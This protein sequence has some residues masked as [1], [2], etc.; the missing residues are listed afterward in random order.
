MEQ[1]DT[2]EREVGLPDAKR[3]EALARLAGGVAHDLNNILGA[4]D[5]YASLLLRTLPAEG[6]AALDT[7][8]I[9]R[10][11]AA[12]TALTGRLLAFSRPQIIQKEPVDVKALLAGLA[13]KPGLD[14]SI[15]TE[16]GLPPLQAS[17]G[18]LGGALQ[19][20]LD[21]A[22]A[23]VDRGGAVRIKAG[24]A[25]GETGAARLRITVE[26]TGC[27]M[28]PEVLEHAF[29]PYFTTRDKGQGRGLG[30]FTVRGAVLQHSGTAEIRSAPG[31]GTEVTISLPLA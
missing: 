28:P 22:A 21:N 7:R 1:K 4:I 3:L 14:L 26:D 8:E 19:C 11:A 5:G 9:R 16:P 13:C 10:A 25:R 2:R 12:A 6:Q 17:P 20:L 31:A 18:L 29:E 15:E 24:L 23:A 30:L 27:G